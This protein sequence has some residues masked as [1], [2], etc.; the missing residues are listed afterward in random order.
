MSEVDI[1][2]V[3]G[4]GDLR[5]TSA[6]YRELMEAISVIDVERALDAFRSTQERMDDDSH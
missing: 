5:L 2:F 6:A 1:E 3:H 4:D